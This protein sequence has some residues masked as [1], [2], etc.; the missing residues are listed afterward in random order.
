MP[1]ISNGAWDLHHATPSETDAMLEWISLGG[2]GLDTAFSY[3]VQDQT[4]MG[5]AVRNASVPRKELFVTT[6]IPCA[7]NAS[8]ALDYVRQDL[9]QLKLPYVDLLLIHQ[10]NGCKTAAELQVSL[11]LIY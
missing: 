9:A 2:R 3:G 6:K 10:P 7:G 8:S 5:A 1:W 11:N 4:G